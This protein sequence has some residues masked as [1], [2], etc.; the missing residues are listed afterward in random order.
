MK[1]RAL[2]SLVVITAF[3]A[4]AGSAFAQAPAGGQYINQPIVV[5][6]QQVQGVMM[7]ANGA[8][9]TQSCPAP[10]RYVTPN[11]SS[12]GW[13]CFDQTSQTWI[14]PAMPAA[15]T[16]YPSAPAPTY[17]S[18]SPVYVDS[19][20]PA[21]NYSY[22][23]YAYSYLPAPYYAYPY[24]YYPY[25]RYPAFSI[26]FGFGYGYGYRGPYFGRPYVPFGRVGGVGG[27]GVGRVGF[28]RVGGR[29]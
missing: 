26:G 11:Q 17:Q 19:A 27:P 5:N 22:Y 13:A 25:Y 20:P 12:T 28:G 18:Q 7:V 21:Y 14:L 15:Q 4:S 16:A 6:G 23:P 2:L 9:Q 8:I 3:A 10:Q 29:R 24:G 1:F